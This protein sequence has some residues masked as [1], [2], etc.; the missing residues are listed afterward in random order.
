MCRISV[1]SPVSDFITDVNLFHTSNAL[2]TLDSYSNKFIFDI[3]SFFLS[4]PMKVGGVVVTGVCLCVCLSVCQS[5]HRIS[6][7]IIQRFK[8]NY[9]V[10]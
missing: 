4:P 6:H 1:F 5:V 3:I 10:G 8:Q 9:V 7:K 2:H